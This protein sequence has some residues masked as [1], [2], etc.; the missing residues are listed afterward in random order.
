MYDKSRICLNE[1]VKPKDTPKRM[2]ERKFSR[3]LWNETNL[4][5]RNVQCQ[6]EHI[7]FK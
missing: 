7:N 6:I 2:S 4:A 3:A 1:V 5:Q